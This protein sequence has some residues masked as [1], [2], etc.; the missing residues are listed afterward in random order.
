MQVHPR[1]LALAAS[2]PLGPFGSGAN[3]RRGASD[4]ST[5]K[6]RIPDCFTAIDP[7]ARLVDLAPILRALAGS[8]IEFDLELGYP[9]ARARID[10]V[11]FDAT[12]LELVTAACIAGARRIVVRNRKV[13]ARL[14]ILVCDDGDHSASGTEIPRI[15]DF[16][17]GAHGQLRARYRARPGRAV[18]LTFPTILGVAD[19]RA[20]PRH[21]LSPRKSE[22]KSHVQD[23][24]PVAA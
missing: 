10:P 21:Y 22:E 13:G 5:G 6:K 14:W 1:L 20:P 2:T 4:P 9:Q 7:G 16:G 15:H 12:I 17:L 3:P 11:G 23:R 19:G 24:Q 18:S 8:S